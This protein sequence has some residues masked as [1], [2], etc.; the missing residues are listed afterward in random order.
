MR[1]QQPEA[2]GGREASVLE[3]TAKPPVRPGAV[4]LIQTGNGIGR[5]LGD[6]LEGL[7]VVVRRVDASALAAMDD[8]AADAEL[9]G[10]LDGAEAA[11]LAADLPLEAPHRVDG[12]LANLRLAAALVRVVESGGPAHLVYISSETVYPADTD[13]VNE[14]SCAAA[15]DLLGGMHRAREVM[16]QSLFRVPVAVLRLAQVYGWP[17]EDRLGP[18]RMLRSLAAGDDIR[19]PGGGEDRRD[20]VL[21]DDVYRV[22]D[23]TL[24]HASRGI[25]NVA[26]G[27]S[28]DLNTVARKVLAVMQAK[29]EIHSIPRA[30]AITHRDFD[31]TAVFKAFPKLAFLPLDQGLARAV[32]RLNGT[33][34]DG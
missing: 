3:H 30:A 1:H 18:D 21:V 13:H 33:A 12:Y 15:A 5:G 7:G 4:A 14:A 28:V 29:S 11:V 17:A 8:R 32:E 25:L 26:T 16:L 9:A 10:S 24:T 23:E 20:Y 31:I 22:V 6:F 19:L 34:A 27:H 2:A